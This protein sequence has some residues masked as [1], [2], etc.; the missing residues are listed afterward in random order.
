M[1]LAKDLVRLERERIFDGP[2]NCMYYI[3]IFDYNF[4]LLY[5][6]N[7]SK[8]VCTN[9]YCRTIKKNLHLSIFTFIGGQINIFKWF[10]IY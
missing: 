2:Q 9:K 6:H 4:L 1:H 8:F 5:L 3:Y 7:T 10:K